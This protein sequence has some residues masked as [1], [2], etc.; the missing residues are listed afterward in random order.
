MRAMLLKKGRICFR[1]S[2]CDKRLEFSPG[3]S[4]IQSLCWRVLTSYGP[5]EV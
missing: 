1:A 3:A 4:G 2:T 5:V